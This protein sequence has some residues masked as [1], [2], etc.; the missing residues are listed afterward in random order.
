[1]GASV[2]AGVGRWLPWALFALGVGL[3]V[4]PVGRSMWFDEVAC[5]E[6]S[7]QSVTELVREPYPNPPLYYLFIHALLQ[8]GVT[9]AGLRLVNAMLS[10]AALA[11]GFRLFARALPPPS[12]N[13]ARGLLAISPFDVYYAQEL[14]MYAALSLLVSALV[15][16]A[17]A[18]RNEPCRPRLWAAYP[19]TAALGLWTHL[20]FALFLLTVC[21]AGL[22]SWRRAPRLWATWL[23]VHTVA[24]LAF[25][26]WLLVLAEARHVPD[27]ANVG[28]S[29][30]GNDWLMW[31]KPQPA[32]SA[33]GT[34]YAFHTGLT[35]PPTPIAVAVAAPAVAAGLALAA[36]GCCARA[37]DWPLWLVVALGPTAAAILV[38]HLWQPIYSAQT[39]RFALP[40][41]PSFIIL[42]SQGW[43]S[44][45]HRWMR[46]G[47][48]LPLLIVAGMSTGSYLTRWPQVGM[49]EF[50]SAAAFIRE[51]DPGG[52][53]T[54]M[55]VRGRDDACAHERGMGD[56]P[57][58][59][60]LGPRCREL[61]ADAALDNAELVALAP[62]DSLWLVDYHDNALV[63]AWYG[64][65]Q[66][67][68]PRERAAAVGVLKACGFRRAAQWISPSRKSMILQRFVRDRR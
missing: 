32:L 22:W 47:A 26:P 58:R 24:G 49:G 30:A 48:A 36:R 37:G 9:E 18:L 41:L 42:Q 5:V 15:W 40:S 1:M 17:L 38:S 4:W 67:G 27:I 20:Y 8:F 23:A 6:R 13:L 29:V 25:V 16:C 10:I 53:L 57:L 50:R 28:Q 34:A 44:L 19:L 43:G 63:S 46:L 56:E 21:A 68:H 60:Y 45:R 33:V 39:V 11:V 64:D 14:K 55:Y 62:V 54:L 31:I 2:T 59:Y 52:A 65:A 7:A 51:H 3:R 61:E 12:A 66:V 35:W